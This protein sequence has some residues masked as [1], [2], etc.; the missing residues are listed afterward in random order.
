ME[1]NL[2]R[3]VLPSTFSTVWVFYAVC[4]LFSLI[5]FFQH[6]SDV[7]VIA[8]Q[9]ELFGAGSSAPV[10]EGSGLQGGAELVEN[11]IK[12][13]G[14]GIIE[15]GSLIKAIIFVIKYLLIFSGI[16]ALFAFLYAGFLY[17]K[18]FGDDGDTDTAKS[19]M[20]NAAI[21]IIIILF[22][23]VVVDFLTTFDL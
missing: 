17:I 3:H 11:E 21:G 19:A 14:T 23:W 22:S 13:S 16:L 6:S 12:G 18:S 5:L 2:Q 10:F 9:A 15:E 4:G 20:I 1:N 8:L 7:A